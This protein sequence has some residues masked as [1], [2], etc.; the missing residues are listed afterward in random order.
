MKNRLY[1][2]FISFILLFT[3]SLNAQ[4]DYNLEDDLDKL[5]YEFLEQNPHWAENA[6]K[7]Y[8]EDG[9]VNNTV[10]QN[11]SSDFCNFAY[12]EAIQDISPT[13]KEMMKEDII[14]LCMVMLETAVIDDSMQNQ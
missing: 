11:L 3:I 10:L 14:T 8:N 12:H 4:E 6:K 7:L 5:L 9:T 13:L 2:L 1:L